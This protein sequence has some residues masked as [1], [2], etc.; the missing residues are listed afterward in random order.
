MSRPQVHW[1]T[2]IRVVNV[3]EWRLHVGVA[4]VVRLNML[5]FCGGRCKL[6]RNAAA[7]G[8]LPCER[9]LMIINWIPVCRQL[10]HKPLLPFPP[11][12]HIWPITPVRFMMAGPR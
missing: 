5:M 10:C 2:S 12:P 7:L 4:D 3:N 8:D 1:K 6:A 11:L 9:R